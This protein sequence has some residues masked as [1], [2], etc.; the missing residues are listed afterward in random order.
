MESITV[1]A[2][3]LYKMLSSKLQNR[4]TDLDLVLILQKLQTYQ[5]AINTKSKGAASNCYALI[6]AT[7]HQISRPWGGDRRIPQ[8]RNRN[9]IQRAAY[10]GHKRHHGLKFQS[11]VVPDGM[12]VQMFGPVEGWR[13]HT[14]ILRESSL[15]QRV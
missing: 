13:H 8:I 14:I 1:L 15:S 11:V 9:N 12:L 6:D 7:L 5:Q 2:L 10:S 4:L 3:T